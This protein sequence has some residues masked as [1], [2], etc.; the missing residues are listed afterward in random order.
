MKLVIDSN[1]LVSAYTVE[2]QIHSLWQSLCNDHIRFVSPEIFAEVERTLRETQFELNETQVNRILRD[3]LYRCRLVRAKEPYEDFIA[4]ENDRHLAELAIAVGA[5][6][7]IT[8]DHAIRDAG[9]V[10]GTMVSSLRE[11]MRCSRD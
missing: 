7:I 8:G 6:R 11:V 1:I 4:D 10:A 9:Y 5:D 2:G 3:I